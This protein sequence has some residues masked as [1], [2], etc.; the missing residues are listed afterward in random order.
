MMW[1][2]TPATDKQRL[3]EFFYNERY[4]S[5]GAARNFPAQ[6][7]PCDNRQ[8]AKASTSGPVSPP[9][10]RKPRREEGSLLQI[11]KDM[12]SWIY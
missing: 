9:D 8:H 10:D 1:R 3:V 7:L 6:N 11:L 4:R 12:D 2:C 5:M